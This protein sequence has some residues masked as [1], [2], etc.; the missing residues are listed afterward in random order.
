MRTKLFRAVIICIL[1]SGFIDCSS[2]GKL[3]GSNSSNA[4]I[5]VLRRLSV[6]GSGRIAVFDN[7]KSVGT[8]DRGSMLSWS[9]PAG[10]AVVTASHGEPEAKVTL[11]VEANQVYYVEV[12]ATHATA[13]RPKVVV[14][15]VLSS[16]EGKHLLSTLQHE[17]GG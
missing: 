4:K 14:L 12:K 3:T 10:T 2:V 5:Y 13:D 8:I 11:T 1:S 17:F 7:G 16:T 9:R 6:T 15:Q